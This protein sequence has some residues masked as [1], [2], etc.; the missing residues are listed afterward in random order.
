MKV[1][2][3][4]SDK[5]E[6]KGYEGLCAVTGVGAIQAAAAAAK[7]IAELR[8]DVII[9]IGSA[10][11]FGKL[12]LG[13]SYSFGS[14]VSG[15]Q[16][17]TAYRLPKGATLGPGRETVSA[18]SLDKASPYVLISSCRFAGGPSA[19]EADAADMEAYGVAMAARQYGI[20]CYAVKVMTDIIGER[21]SIP[22]YSKRL[23][24]WRAGL[25]LKVE[26]LLQGL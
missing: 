17:L 22:D 23:R 6:L 15:D 18:L 11:S 14:V 20:P 26:E 21:V 12:E 8:P 4:A 1:L 2:L 24:E 16:D 3:A 9:S 10:G 5:A 19:I 7:A 25:H 13:K